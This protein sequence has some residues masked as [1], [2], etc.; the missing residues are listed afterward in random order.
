MRICH[1]TSHLPPDQGASALLPVHLGEWARD[2]GDSVVYV[3]HPPNGREAE[4]CP[5][6][7]VTVRRRRR[8]KG[9][10]GLLGT[11]ILATSAEIWTKAR[12]SVRS[13]DVIHVHSNGLLPELGVLFGRSARKP[14]V[15]TLYGTEVWHYRKRRLSL[16]LF[17]RTYRLAT[18]VAFY[19]WGLLEH[20]RAVGLKRP[21]MVAIYP[22][23]ADQ[24]K[25][26][27]PYRPSVD[28]HQVAAA[29]RAE[30]GFSRQHLLVNVKR[31]HPLGGHRTLIEAFAK[32]VR[33]HPDTHLVVIGS[34]PLEASLRRFARSC[35]VADHI[36]FAGLIGNAELWK[37]YVAAD[38]FVLPSLLEACPTVA[39]EALACATPVISTDNPGGVELH[40]VFGEDVTLVPRENANLLAG[41][42][43]QALEQKRRVREQTLQTLDR[44]FRASAIASKYWDLYQTV[45]QSRR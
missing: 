27:G 13:A 1:F 21:G 44:D 23:V 36:T 45:L 25:P 2:R 18:R 26:G 43:S 31:L 17:T 20:A 12:S 14:V 7:T 3:A 40:K 30:L 38:L 39:L 11:R 19:S 29:L 41:A 28:M 42:I 32:L 15:L 24:F 4:P 10:R 34:G 22:P 6:V 8:P 9:V 33:T 16:D 5:G 35:G 37:Y